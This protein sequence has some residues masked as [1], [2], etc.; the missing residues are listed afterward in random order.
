MHELDFAGIDIS[1]LKDIKDVRLDPDSPREKRIRSF[2]AQ[3]GNPYCYRDGDVIVSIS[4]AD[5]DVR[6]EDRLKA[7]ASGLV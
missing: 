4:Y 3:I 1:Q 2:I 7:Y 5:T 6:L